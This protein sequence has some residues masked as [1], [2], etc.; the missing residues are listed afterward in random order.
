MLSK[1]IEKKD[2]VHTYLPS[3]SIFR[4]SCKGKK[5]MRVKNR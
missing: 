4:Q 2:A 1:D 5:V 3:V